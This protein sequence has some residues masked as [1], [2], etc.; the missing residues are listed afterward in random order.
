PSASLPIG[1]PPV[2]PSYLQRL[3]T[4]RDQHLQEYMRLQE[5]IEDLRGGYRDGCRLRHLLNGWPHGIDAQDLK[6]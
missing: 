6:K 2:G 3:A 1:C 4:L 5:I